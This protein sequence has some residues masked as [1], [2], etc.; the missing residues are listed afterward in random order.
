MTDE[1]VHSEFVKYL[2]SFEEGETIIQEGDKEND[3]YCLLQGKVGVWKGDLENQTSRLKIGELS[4]KGTYFGEMSCLLS[5]PR[6]ATITALSPVKVLR[7][8]GEMLSQMILKQPK[9]GLKLCTAMADRLRGTTGDQHDIAAQRN[10]L[11][12]DATEQFLYAR[13]AYQRLFIMLT[14]VQAQLQNPL[15]KTL[16]EEMSHDRLMQGGKRLK[17]NE[18]FL[19]EMPSEIGQLVEKSYAHLLS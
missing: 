3:F 17:I 19:K 1:A 10:E 11:R 9:L 4:E 5:E 8:P 15:L 14:S 16:V 12:E 7:F 6:T 2:V 18:K 13:E